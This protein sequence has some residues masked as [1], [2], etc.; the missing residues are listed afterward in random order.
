MGRMILILVIGAGILIA[1]I[2]LN[3]NKSTT[4]MSSNV[5]DKYQA[6]QAKNY[7]ESGVEYA[8]ENLSEDTTWTGE[9]NISIGSGSVSITVENTDNM[10]YEGPTESISSGR[11]V[12]SV[13]SSGSQT[14][15]VRAVIQ[16]PTATPGTT[17][18]PTIFQYAT[19]NNGDITMSGNTTITDDNDPNT[20]ANIQTNGSFSAAGSTTINGF[21]TYADTFSDNRYSTNITPNQNPNND[22]AYQQTTP[23]TWPTFNAD[24]FKSLATTTYTG[25]YKISGN[26]TIGSASDPQIIY[27]GGNLTISGLFKGYAV[28][29]VKGNIKISGNSTLNSEDGAGNDLG[30][31]AQGSVTISGLSEIYAQI[32][33]GSTVK[34]SGNSTV[35]GGVAAAGSTTMS[36][37]TNI[38][39]KKPKG[40]ITQGIWQSSSDNTSGQTISTMPQVVSYYE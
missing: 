1:E 2:T 29:I 16:L 19:A 18:V 39:Y 23:I 21:V 36:G 25:N 20:N 26:T 9:D 3:I 38:Y 24:D 28:F 17:T 12:T 35:Y 22:P 27:V 11:L 13:G 6:F 5:V 15:T 30:L 10:Y 14:D 33:S 34:I 4:T 8:V 7:A 40:E 37:L 32:Y 31:Y